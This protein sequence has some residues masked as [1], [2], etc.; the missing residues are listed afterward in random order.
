V[1]VNVK[2]LPFLAMLKPQKELE[3]QDVTFF[4]LSPENSKPPP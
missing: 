3:L 1:I 4:S 2:K